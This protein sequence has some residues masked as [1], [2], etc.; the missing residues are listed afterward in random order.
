M[1]RLGKILLAV[2]F[3]ATIQASQAVALT[4]VQNVIGEMGTVNTA[5]KSVL[6]ENDG[7]AIANVNLIKQNEL[8]QEQLDTRLQPLIDV[9][10]KKSEV[11]IANGQRITREINRHNS[12]CSGTVSQPV[13]DKCMSEAVVLKRVSTKHYAEKAV[14]KKERADLDKEW[15]S[16]ANLIDANQKT[17]NKNF[18]RHLVIKDAVAVYEQLLENYRSQLIELC[19]EAD[20]DRDGESLHHCNAI[21]WDGT[22]RSLPPLDTIL[23]GTKFFGN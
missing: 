1:N 12:G 16:Y 4:A 10:L 23:K 11:H 9:H 6:T 22:Q 13:Y 2:T 20:T 21:T 18:Q 7:L 17:I 15:K 5:M 14:L 8:W 3:F 19:T